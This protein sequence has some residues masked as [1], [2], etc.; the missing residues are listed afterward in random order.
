VDHVL[1]HSRG[2][3][4]TLLVL[5]VIAHHADDAGMAELSEDQIAAEVARAA[6][7]LLPVLAD[8]LRPGAAERVAEI[9]GGAGQ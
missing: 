9:L 8:P 7:E 1:R 4:E 3:T 5:L 2:D 6:P